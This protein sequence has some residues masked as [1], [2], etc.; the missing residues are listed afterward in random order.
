MSIYS[1]VY[2]TCKNNEEAE[3]LSR[4]FLEK[5]LVVCANIIDQVRS[6][7]KFEGKI[8]SESEVVLLLKTESRL[9]NE[10]KKIIKRLHSYEVPCIMEI[11]VN[12]IDINFGQWITDSLSYS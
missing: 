7:Y 5:N 10:I 4:T 2:L 6:I 9:F 8:C 3:H 11:K 12:D 1:I